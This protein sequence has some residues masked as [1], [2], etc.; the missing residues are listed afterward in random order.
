MK[1]AERKRGFILP[2][3]LT[4]VVILVI[5][6]SAR[7][8]FSRQQLNTAAKL[9]DY[10]RSYQASVSGLIA[11][12]AVLSNAVNFINDPAPETFPKREKAPAGIKPVVESLLDENGRFRAAETEFDLAT[13]LDS[14]LKKNF[15]DLEN[16]LIT[17]KL[18]RGKPLYLETARA[19]DFEVTNCQND[20]GCSFIK[21][22]PKESDYILS[23]RV[24]C[25]V[26]NSKCVVG[27]FTECRIVNIIPPVLGKFTLFLRSI[28]GLKINSISDT[29][30]SSN[31]KISPA[32]INNGMPAAAPSGLEPSKMRDMI[33]RQG[34][35]YLGGAARW[36][37]NLTYA[38]SSAN[39]CEGPLLRDYYYYSI[40]ADQTL[41]ASSSLRYYATESPLYSELGDIATGEPLNLKKK[42]EYS[43]TS[44]LNLFGSS[45]ALSPTVIIGD[46]SRSYA[47]LQGIYN[48]SSKKYAPL[49]Y[50]DQA[51]FSSPNWP[52]DMSAATV[53]LIRNNFKNDLKNYQK[54]MS[55][56][57]VGHYNAANLVPLDLKNQ[58]SLK[59]MAFDQQE[60]AKSFP[61][62]PNMS[63][64]RANM[65]PAAFYKPLYENRYTIFDD[66]GK[67]LYHGDD[68]ARFYDRNLLSHKAGY[69]FK[70]SLA[71]WKKVYDQKKKL[72]SLS[73]I[74][75]VSGPLDIFERMSVARGG[76]G[77][78]IAEGDIRIR[79]GISAPDSEPVT[80][81]SSKGD[82][83]VETSER[84]DAAL[85]AVSGRLILPASFDIKGLAAARE[86]SMAPG[87]PGAT[88]KLTYNA[89]FDPTDYRNYSANYRMMI[90][91]EWQNFVE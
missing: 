20:G 78:I 47:L 83:Y 80:L 3:A 44:V 42:D 29:S 36:N 58:N 64:L 51:A 30:I 57:I 41:N 13:S 52:G 33:D 38:A 73:S 91:G 11:A 1:N 69:V 61:D 63:R 31:F 50:L 72:L 75:K 15:Q 25:A 68:P 81:V 89:V 7:L 23:V 34:W 4:V 43:N 53:D 70:N 35:I 2:G 65:I 28:G 27:S 84:V 19:K 45:A 79:G 86:L 22:D 18:G 66:R 24:V 55:D 90:K 10:E 82:I 8:Y 12:R 5:M 37:F 49:P 14:Y 48:S 40:D 59:T 87:R 26:G 60:F 62:F 71:L 54:R 85:V 21:A 9:S 77:I 16:I 88:R 6:A 76:G 46:V 56:V 67:L 32:V 39:F 17:V 74:V